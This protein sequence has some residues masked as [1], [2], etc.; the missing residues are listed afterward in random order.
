MEQP[1]QAPDAEGLSERAKDA[2]LKLTPK[3]REFWRLWSTGEA[4]SPAEAYRRAFE[5]TNPKTAANEGAKL[6]RT[7]KFLVLVEERRRILAEQFLVTEQR[8]LRSFAT[9]AWT[10]R[11]QFF[12][13]DGTLKHPTE[14]TA[15]QASLVTAVD[16][17]ELFEGQGEDRTKV[18]ELKK[19][20]LVSVKDTLDSLART[21]GMFI[22]VR[23]NL[24]KNY[25]F[26][27]PKGQS[28]AEWEKE[29]PVAKGGNGEHPSVKH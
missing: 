14:L 4:K 12:R 9:L 15:E 11:R 24:N 16:V 21:Q 25:V 10:D 27:T 26:R 19:L 17:V 5:T 28:R 18:G 7:E 2:L 3:Q 1:D 13:E 8:I 20:R 29:H 22:E 6:L 23:E